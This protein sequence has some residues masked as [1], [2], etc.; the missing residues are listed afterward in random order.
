MA[1]DRNNICITGA[2]A[3]FTIVST[4][5]GFT[6][7]GVF[8][9]VDNE[10]YDVMMDQHLALL[11]KPLIGRRCSVRTVIGEATL[12]QMRAAWNLN[13][14]ALVSSSLEVDASENGEVKII[15]TG[16]GPGA[17]PTT[18]TATFHKAVAMTTDEV[19]Y[20]KEGETLIPVEFD[21]IWDTT[22]SCYC[23]IVDA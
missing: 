9:R 12:E 19:G 13:A 14:T 18:R 1:V 16:K 21:V 7:G 3:T 6:K 5:V 4:D 22:N 10:W 17:T 8:M 15:F 2:N 11:K 20:I 23:S